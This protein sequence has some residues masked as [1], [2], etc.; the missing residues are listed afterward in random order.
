MLWKFA[1][2]KNPAER[3]QKLRALEATA[4]TQPQVWLQDILVSVFVF[5]TVMTILFNLSGGA[6]H[7]VAT[8]AVLEFVFHCLALVIAMNVSRFCRFETK[9]S[10]AWFFIVCMLIAAAP[11]LIAVEALA[12]AGWRSGDG[13]SVCLMAQQS[14]RYLRLLEAGEVK[15]VMEESETKE[16]D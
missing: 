3:S 14:T 13:Y 1:I 5:G 10:R 15:G 12:Y 11:M 16:P 4:L 7:T 2:L 8:F 6:P 9:A